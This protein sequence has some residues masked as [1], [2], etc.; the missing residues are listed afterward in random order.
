MMFCF[1]FVYLLFVLLQHLLIWFCLDQNIL[2]E[3]T[4]L[5]I[6]TASTAAK[7]NMG[8]LKTYK[9]SA[10]QLQSISEGHHCFQ[11][12][13]LHLLWIPDIAYTRRSPQQFAQGQSRSQLKRWK[14]QCFWF[15]LPFFHQLQDYHKNTDHFR[16]FVGEG[17]HDSFLF[18]HQKIL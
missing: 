10:L 18:R 11:C 9:Y 17:E 3:M 15:F 16:L 5:K 13:A 1:G 8:T 2:M 14:N 4:P 7:D 12:Y 6:G